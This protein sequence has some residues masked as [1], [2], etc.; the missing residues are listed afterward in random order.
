MDD[1]TWLIFAGVTVLLVIIGVVLLILGVWRWRVERAFVAHAAQASG[2]VIGFERLPM[3]RSHHSRY[4][5]MSADYPVVRYTPAAGS[6]I[7]FR[8]TIGSSPRA[9]HEGEVVTIL[10]DPAEP[11]RAMIQAG[12]RQ[13]LLPLFLLGLGIFLLLFA[14]AFGGGAW[15]QR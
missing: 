10:Y 8:S 11:Q 13:H 6:A 14:V 4:R 2:M 1:R 9:Y 5:S 15:W 3:G 7:E 12:L